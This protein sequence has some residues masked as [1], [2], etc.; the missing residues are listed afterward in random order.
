[1]GIAKDVNCIYKIGF[2]ENIVEQ[3]WSVKNPM[4]SQN[5]LEKTFA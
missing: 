4:Q 3:F 5:S 1:M 2:H